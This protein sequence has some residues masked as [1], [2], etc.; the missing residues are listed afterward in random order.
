MTIP[1]S[2]P[3]NPTP[4]TPDPTANGVPAAVPVVSVK[5]V[6]L[7]APGRGEELRVRVS[8]PVTG[9]ELPI[10]LLAHG[11]GSSLEGYGPLADHWAAHGLVVVQPT[12]LDSR[13]VGL[14]PEDP[15][16]P[17]IWRGR[18]E[19]M[20][21]VL[22]HLDALEAAV[23]GLG[24]RLDRGRVAAAGH[25]FGGQTAGLLLGLRVPDPG[26]GEARDLSDPRVT[27]GVLLA[28]AGRGGADLTP[29]AAERF[30][31]LN[32]DFAHLTR[33]A[34][35]VTGDRDDSPLTVRGPDWTADPY[36]L[37]PG[38]KSLLT[39][40]GAEHSLGG[41]VGYEAAETTDEHPARVALV[42]WV[43][44]AYLRHALGVDGAGWAAALRAL[45]GNAHPL[46]RL[47][48]RGPGATAAARGRRAQA[49][50]TRQ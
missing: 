22:D 44:L 37:S 20:R 7:P 32:P 30:P 21:R 47:D 4:H 15:R 2:T 49:A 25:S 50:P 11:F 46:G 48:T 28:T 43:T 1:D 36:H 39:L 6:T 10:V 23:P 27:A 16:T 45:S 33:P 9:E 31:F 24:G 38:E 26:T 29:A 8:A 18:V 35:V 34:L 14:P 42:Q 12:H 13:T 40:F 17:G 3:S 5:P 41:V 19:D